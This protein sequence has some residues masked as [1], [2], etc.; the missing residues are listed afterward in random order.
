MKFDNLTIHLTSIR[1]GRKSIPS[2]QS[3]GTVIYTLFTFRMYVLLVVCGSLRF[4]VGL[5]F[6]HLKLSHLILAMNYSFRSNH[7]IWHIWLLSNMK[8]LLWRWV[9]VWVW[10]YENF[11][12]TFCIA[13]LVH[14]LSMLHMLFEYLSLY[15]WARMANSMAMSCRHDWITCQFDTC[16]HLFLVNRDD[17]D[18]W[19]LLLG[20]NM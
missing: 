3:H 5:M 17:D 10:G 20:S 7:L 13:T 11:G 8:R 9:W 14:M 19:C 6:F 15:W 12:W 2:L 18:R 1:E 4:V 16:K